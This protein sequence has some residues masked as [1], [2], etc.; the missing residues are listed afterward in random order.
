[1]PSDISPSL[2]TDVRQ[3]AAWVAAEASHVRIDTVAVE[4]LAATLNVTDITTRGWDGRFH[5]ADRSNPEKL[6]AY[7]LCLDAVNFG[8]GYF[9]DMTYDRT[10]YSSGYYYV[11]DTLKYLFTTRDGFTA[12]TLQA[13]TAP[14]AAWLFQQPEDRPLMTLFAVAW[15][16]LGQAVAAAGSFSTFVA[17]ANGSAARLVAQL[18]EQPFFRDTWEYRGRMVP[19]LKR[20]QIAVADLH[21][22]FAGEGLW[23][24]HD[25]D[26]LTIFADN[27]V[28]AVL[29]QHGV[30]NYSAELQSRLWHGDLLPA[31]APEEIEIRAAAIHAGELLCAALNTLHPKAQIVPWQLDNFLWEEG[32]RLKQEKDFLQMAW[33]AH[34]TQ[35]VC[36]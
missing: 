7:V 4:R 5:Y 24:F 29:A 21:L 30:L 33:L 20:A 12:G 23:A 17:N 13:L 9:R 27:R 8:S 11:A 28:P 32:Q 16:N 15:R 3:Q 18:A 31:G 36:Y 19:L 14:Q 26:Q 2:L 10:R 35:S 25:L 1:L 22:A 6:A 34:R